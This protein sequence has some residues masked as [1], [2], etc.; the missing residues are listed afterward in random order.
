MHRYQPDTIARIR[1][2]YVH[3]QQSRYRT[4]IA[5]LQQR[6]NGASTRD[7]VKLTKQLNKLEAQAEEIRIFEEK[8]HHLADQMIPIDLD[9]GVKGNYAKFA[10][11][12]AKMK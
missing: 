6:I 9:D 3:E 11:V 10:D 8:I 4:A 2:D 7:R 12:L 5:D 1:T